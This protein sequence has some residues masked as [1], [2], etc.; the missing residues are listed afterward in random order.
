MTWQRATCLTWWD[1]QD[2]PQPEN[3]Q[4]PVPAL[5]GRNYSTRRSELVVRLFH[6]LSH[7]HVRRRLT[8]RWDDF[9]TVLQVDLIKGS[10]FIFH[11]CKKQIPKMFK[12]CIILFDALGYQRGSH[13]LAALESLLIK[14]LHT[15]S[16]I[17]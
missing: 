6:L 3:K 14:T 12:K 1:L 17:L 7:T 15:L 5:G 11:R 10:D 9:M 2:H 4:D 16:H 13:L 8:G